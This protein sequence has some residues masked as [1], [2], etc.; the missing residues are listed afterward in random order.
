LSGRI[1]IEISKTS[2][3]PNENI[4]GTV[5][6]NLDKPT[7]SKGVFVSLTSGECRTAYR[8]GKN[9]TEHYTR[10]WNSLPL[11]IEKEY[12]AAQVFTY[13]FK[14]VAPTRSA[15][16][17]PIAMLWKSFRKDTTP[18]SKNYKIEAKL[19]ISHGFDVNSSREITI[20]YT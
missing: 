15:Q 9:V 13:P 1:G 6:L 2:F 20:S 19:D 4:E 8:N 7:M 11:D 10:V 16:F 17:N 5:T 14:L 18:R 3:S 12:P